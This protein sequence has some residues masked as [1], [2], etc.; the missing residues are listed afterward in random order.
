MGQDAQD[1]LPITHR[2][3]ESLGL[4]KDQEVAELLGLSA[5][6]FSDRKRRGAF[7]TDK[8]FALIATRPEL[9]IDVGYVLSGSTARTTDSAASAALLA[10]LTV[11]AAE[12][13]PA[14]DSKVLTD[15]VSKGITQK[16]TRGAA[17]STSY[18]Q[19]LLALDCLD[20]Q[21]F[22]LACQLVSQLVLA[23]QGEELAQTKRGK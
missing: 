11:R 18:A 21:R 14:K 8:L 6:A 12:L 16:A 20:D 10:G 5:A 4:D 22:A 9:N 3:K 19:L 7:P 23:T 13:L 15:V 1:F 17:R 2:L